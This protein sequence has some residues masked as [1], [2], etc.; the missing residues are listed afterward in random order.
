[1]IVHGYIY[2]KLKIKIGKKNYYKFEDRSSPCLV[3]VHK[4]LMESHKYI[5]SYIIYVQRCWCFEKDYI[6]VK[7]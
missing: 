4:V 7:A 5:H 6:I 2:E 1:M 3:S